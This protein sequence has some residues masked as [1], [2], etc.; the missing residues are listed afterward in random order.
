MEGN[1]WLICNFLIMCFEL[2]SSNCT[3]KKYHGIKHASQRDMQYF[4][5]F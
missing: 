2:A 3:L 5:K 1:V 4:H